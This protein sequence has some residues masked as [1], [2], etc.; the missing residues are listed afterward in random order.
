M[1]RVFRKQADL[2]VGIDH[3]TG[4]VNVKGPQR[5]GHGDAD[6]MLRVAAEGVGN[7]TASRADSFPLTTEMMS[8]INFGA[9]D[10][11]LS[12]SRWIYTS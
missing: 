9:I 12:T 8:F 6:V 3:G 10:G 4:H 5:R 11:S 2:G 7:A 1:Q